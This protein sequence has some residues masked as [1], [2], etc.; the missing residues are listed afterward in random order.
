MFSVAC[1]CWQAANAVEDPSDSSQAVLDGFSPDVRTTYDV[2]HDLSLDM[3]GFLPDKENYPGLRPAA[4]FFFGGGWRQGSTTQFFPFCE[5]LASRG[6]ACFV[7]DYR[8]LDRQGTDA[9][10]ALEDARTALAWVRSRASEYGIDSGRLY[11][12]GGS[13][14]GHLAAA[15]GVIPDS[16]GE[17][18][19][20]V[21]LLLFNPVL[22]L[23]FDRLPAEQRETLNARFRGAPLDY[24]PLEFVSKGLPPT[25][26]VHGEADT[27]VPI[28]SALRFCKAMNSA[29]NVCVVHGYAGEPHGFFNRGRGAYASVLA[30]LLE[31]LGLE[32]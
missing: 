18:P 19:P 26:I 11:A 31:H 14:G 3:F 15:A 16:S 9:V 17:L 4:V 13:A 23:N 8:V 7:P 1:W 21:G 28:A 5:A 32:D 6:V 29:G 27:V 30:R 12:G 2:T 22:D 24:S 25:W 10:T 20:L